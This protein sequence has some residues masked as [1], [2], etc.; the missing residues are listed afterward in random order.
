MNDSSVSAGPD[1]GPNP[2]RD[3][4]SGRPTYYALGKVAGGHKLELRDKISLQSPVS[5]AGREGHAC[6]ESAACRQVREQ[7]ARWAIPGSSLPIDP[8]RGRVAAPWRG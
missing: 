3:S 6:H 4:C 8:A 2:T 1:L 7:A 5:R